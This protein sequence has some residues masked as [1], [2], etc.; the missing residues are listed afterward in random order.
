M[1]FSSIAPQVSGVKQLQVDR[2]ANGKALRL[3]HAWHAW[4][5]R[6]AGSKACRVK[7]RSIQEQV[8]AQPQI[9]SH[10]S[11]PSTKKGWQGR[12][13][14]RTSCGWQETWTLRAALLDSPEEWFPLSSA[15]LAPGTKREHN[16]GPQVQRPGDAGTAGRP[17]SGLPSSGFRP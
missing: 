16:L 17:P 14:L 3:G 12:L 6:A 11:E 5:A 10:F 13:P 9:R 4:R 8:R 7:T 1:S 2:M 15:C